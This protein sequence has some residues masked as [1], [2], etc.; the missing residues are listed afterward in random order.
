MILAGLPVPALSYQPFSL[1]LGF[2]ERVPSKHEPPAV[3][4]FTVVQ[5][6]RLPTVRFAVKFEFAINTFPALQQRPHMFTRLRA[7]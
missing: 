6:L 7:R 5:E 4:E 2:L 1:R 3:R